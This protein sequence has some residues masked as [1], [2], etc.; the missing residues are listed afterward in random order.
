MNDIVVTGYDPSKANPNKIES[1]VLNDFG[2]EFE[3]Y[4][5]IITIEFQ[6]ISNQQLEQCVDIDNGNMNIRLYK[7]FKSCVKRIHGLCYE[8]NG[9]KKEYTPQDIANYSQM[10]ARTSD[11]LDVG[12]LF[13][14]IVNM[15]VLAITGK[16]KL[17][18]PEIKN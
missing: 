13:S 1:Y 17:T 5:G 14:A 9:E 10:D 11:G 12:R 7:I 16:S 4:N 3:Q 6:H 8:R 15:S 18:E 2:G